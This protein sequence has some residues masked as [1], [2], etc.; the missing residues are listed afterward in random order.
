MVFLKIDENSK[1]AITNAL[2][3]FETPPTNVS[4]LNAGYREYLTLNPLTSRPFHFKLFPNTTFI[5]TTKCYLLTEM[6]IK[7]YNINGQ[8]INIED[9]DNVAPIQLIGST[10]IRNIKISISGKEVKKP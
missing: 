8:L 7:K 6:R 5:D 9:T 4:I 2:N 1:N 10:F 3:F